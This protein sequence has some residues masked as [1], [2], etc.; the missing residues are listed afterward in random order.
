MTTRAS[1]ILWSAGS[2]VLLGLFVDA[3]IVGIWVVASSIVPAMTP[4]QLPRWIAAL[5]VVALAAVPIA[6][7]VLGY[8]EGRLKID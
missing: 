1:I 7:G 8:L 6:A 3:A 2:G 5:A 4:R